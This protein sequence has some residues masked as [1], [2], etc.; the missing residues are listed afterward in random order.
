MLT[1]AWAEVARGIYQLPA[2]AP[3][4]VHLWETSV[5]GSAAILPVVARYLSPDERARADRFR[6]P[7]D[8]DSYVLS[9]GLL[10]RLLAS[11][12]NAPPERIQLAYGPYGKPMVEMGTR[13]EVKFNVSHSGDMVLVGF[14]AQEL[15][16]DIER[17][18]ADLDFAGL[19][20]TSFSR[21]EEDAVLALP[22]ERRAS[23]FYEY[24]SC[25]EACIKADGRGLSAPLKQFSIVPSPAGKDWR[26]VGAAAPDVFG[27][28]WRIRT[29]NEIGGYAAAVAKGGDEWDVT[30]IR[31]EPDGAR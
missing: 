26:E 1:A 11:Y 31:L 24:W 15:G 18:Q 29:V 12:T 2:S 30:R 3:D 9:R 10:R 8:R 13:P 23:L 19:A 6:F 5:S 28:Q 22:A 14:A 25:K 4:R 20:K 21:I 7:R 16:V 27:T 17:M